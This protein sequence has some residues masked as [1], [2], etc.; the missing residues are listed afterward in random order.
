MQDPAVQALF[1]ERRFV[2]V[3]QATPEGDLLAVPQHVGQ[4]AHG[5]ALLGL[6]GVPGHGQAQ[7]LVDPAV[8]VGEGNIGFIGRGL[9]GH[10]NTGVG[11]E[12]AQV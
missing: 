3:R 8:Q 6:G 11:S 12:R 10:G 5:Q 7:R 4:Q 1:P 2:H 9:Q